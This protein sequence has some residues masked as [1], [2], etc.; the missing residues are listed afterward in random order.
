ML[1]NSKKSLKCKMITLKC[2]SKMAKRGLV[3]ARPSNAQKCC[4]KRGEEHDREEGEMAQ[5]KLAGGRNRG[6]S[7]EEREKVR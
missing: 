2:F 7:R 1:L 4:E 5:K 6:E 3:D